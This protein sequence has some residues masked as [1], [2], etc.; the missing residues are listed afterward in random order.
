MT[1]S[2]PGEEG[3]NMFHKAVEAAWEKKKKAGKKPGTYRVSEILVVTENPI[4]E[5]R[6]ELDEV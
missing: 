4:R 2:M 5:Y 6:I 1:E 3:H